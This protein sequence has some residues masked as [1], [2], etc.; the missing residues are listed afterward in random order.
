MCEHCDALTEVLTQLTGP[1][2]AAVIM[3]RTHARLH[4]PG[5]EQAPNNFLV[6]TA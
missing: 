1:K 6:V 4:E 2:V 5:S 3:R